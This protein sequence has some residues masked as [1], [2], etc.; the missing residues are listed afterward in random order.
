M[1]LMFLMAELAFGPI[2]T[3][4]E[5]KMII[6]RAIMNNGLTNT[7]VSEVITEIGRVVPEGC[8]LPKVE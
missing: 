8:V 6:N 1:V 5:G 2:L 7:Q 4:N 3:C